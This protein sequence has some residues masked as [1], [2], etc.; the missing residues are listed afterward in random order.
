M[1]CIVSETCI[2]GRFLKDCFYFFSQQI[3]SVVAEEYVISYNLIQRVLE[4]QNLYNCNTE[5]RANSNQENVKYGADFSSDF[6][7]T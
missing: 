4:T 3:I 1:H 6:C 5:C 2:G 7:S